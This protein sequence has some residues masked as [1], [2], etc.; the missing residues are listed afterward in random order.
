MGKLA[1]LWSLV[2]MNGACI[3]QLLIVM[4]MIRQTQHM[5][6]EMN[7]CHCL[8]HCYIHHQWGTRCDVVRYRAN[9]QVPLFCYKQEA[10]TQLLV[11][12]DSIQEDA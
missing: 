2:M 9:A 12:I 10:A 7:D 5:H 6:Q 1:P 11:T 4:D 3:A 8:F